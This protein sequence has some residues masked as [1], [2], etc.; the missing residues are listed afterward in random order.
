MADTQMKHAYMII[1]HTNFQQLQTLID[2]LDDERNDIYLHIDK[3][4]KKIWIFTSEVYYEN[5]VPFSGIFNGNGH[6][7]S[8]M[9][10][11]HGILNGVLA[12]AKGQ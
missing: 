6:T 9:H 11:P 4:A 10:I 2:L 3:K 5:P 1:A 8:N 12:G 7:I